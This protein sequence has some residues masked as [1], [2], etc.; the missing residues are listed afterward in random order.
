MKTETTFLSSSQLMLSSGPGDQSENHG[1]RKMHVA[2]LEMHIKND[3]G[4]TVSDS[5]NLETTEMSINNRM[6]KL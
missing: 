2:V 3:H 6:D 1:P 4:W 5:Q